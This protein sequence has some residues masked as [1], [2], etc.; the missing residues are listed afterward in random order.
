MG[1]TTTGYTMELY[2]DRVAEHLYD[3]GQRICLEAQDYIDAIHH[4]NFP[5]IVLE[6][7]AEWYSK[8]AYCFRK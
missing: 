5:S 1:W 4:D 6:A 8:S 7:N 2:T 3:Y